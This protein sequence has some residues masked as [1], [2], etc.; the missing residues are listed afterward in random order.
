VMGMCP[1]CCS[2]FCSFSFF[3]VLLSVAAISSR[4]CTSP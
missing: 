2:S 4:L 1:A 3:V